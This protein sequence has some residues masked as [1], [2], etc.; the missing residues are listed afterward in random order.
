[1][2]MAPIDNGQKIVAALVNAQFIINYLIHVA[3]HDTRVKL[4]HA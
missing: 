1:M 3:K 4:G 2:S